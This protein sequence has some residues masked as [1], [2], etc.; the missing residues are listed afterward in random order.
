MG[1]AYVAPDTRGCAIGQCWYGHGKR[2]TQTRTPWQPAK[3]LPHGGL[4]HRVLRHTLARP[5][6]NSQGRTGAAATG[7][8]W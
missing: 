3:P 2:L 1:M 7:A 4:H 6:A 8:G 5:V